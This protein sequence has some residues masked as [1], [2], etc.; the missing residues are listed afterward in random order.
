MSII[1]NDSTDPINILVSLILYWEMKKKKN[2]IVTTKNTLLVLYIM[3]FWG[4]CWGYFA[5]L[6]YIPH[7]VKNCHTRLSTK[8]SQL[9]PSLYI[10]S[11]KTNYTDFNTIN[12]RRILL[13]WRKCLKVER[14]CFSL[15]WSMLGSLLFNEYKERAEIKRN[16]RQFWFLLRKSV[17]DVGL[18]IALL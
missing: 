13:C 18:I 11:R 16:E 2:T 8:Q 1:I 17:G 14:S 5:N 10:L 3:C 12:N 15:R 9:P 4:T 6:F 7:V